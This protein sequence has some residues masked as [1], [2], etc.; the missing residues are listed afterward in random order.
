MALIPVYRDWDPSGQPWDHESNICIKIGR[1]ANRRRAEGSLYVLET[2][3]SVQRAL[4]TFT[5]KGHPVQKTVP[6]IQALQKWVP[7]RLNFKWMLKFT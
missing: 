3:F 4:C 1:P 7:I 6:I 5:G 2:A